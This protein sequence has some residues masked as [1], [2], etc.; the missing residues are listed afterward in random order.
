M[1]TVALQVLL[2]ACSP[3]E[4]SRARDTMKWAAASPAVHHIPTH[5]AAFQLSNK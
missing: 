5:D 2:W 3:I 1:G 4:R